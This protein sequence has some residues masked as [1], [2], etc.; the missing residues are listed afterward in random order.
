MQKVLITEPIHPAAVEMLK[1]KFEVVQGTGT[2]AD[3]IIREGAG[4]GG[5]LV[6]VAKI[7]AAVIEALPELKAVGKHGIG[8]DNIDVATATQK[9]VCVVNAPTSNINAVAEHTVALIIAMTK[10]LVV[11]DNSTRKEG[12]AKRSAYTNTELLGKTVGLAGF[13]RIARLVGKML[14]GFGVKLVAYDPYVKQED[15]KDLGVTMMSLDEVL[16]CSDFLSV[17]VPLTDETNK[18]FGKETFAKMKKGSYIVNASRGPVLDEDA[19]YDALT[20][21]QLAGAGLDVFDPE[22]PTADNKL[23]S[24]E[25]VV[26]S[27]HNAALTDA[28]L[29]AMAWDSAVGIADVLEGKCPENLVNRDVLEKISF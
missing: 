26:V 22:P 2:D 5:I 24:L 27:P 18:L 12:F 10:N 4:A 19:L 15:V 25:N 9:G 16:A 6:R 20:S 8:V 3:T 29:Y 13:G 1:S 14:S 21:G 7:P 28:A 23:F 17:H 11:L